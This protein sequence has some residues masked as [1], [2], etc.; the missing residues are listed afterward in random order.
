MLFS[1]HLLLNA[2]HGLTGVAFL[3]FIIIA[4]LFT[5]SQSGRTAN[6]GGPFAAAVGLVTF[7]HGQLT[8]V[9]AL[10]LA[11]ATFALTLITILS[12]HAA[13]VKTRTGSLIGVVGTWI[14]GWT[15]LNY[16]F[17]STFSMVEV[18][19]DGRA[20]LQSAP[21]FIFFSFRDLFCNPLQ[22][23]L[24][25]SIPLV[26]SFS[27]ALD[28]ECNAVKA[29][30]AMSVIMLCIMALYFLYSVADYF[31]IAKEDTSSKESNLQFERYIVFFA[32][33]IACLG[34]VLRQIGLSAVV[35]TLSY[36]DST[37]TFSQLQLTARGHQVWQ[38]IGLVLA[39]SSALHFTEPIA[40]PN[41]KE[42]K[43]RQK[44]LAM[45]CILASMFT[46][47]AGFGATIWDSRVLDDQN[48][49]AAA[50]IS[51]P[52]AGGQKCDLFRVIVAGEWMS[53]LAAF[54]VFVVAIIGRLRTRGAD[55]SIPG[56][57]EKASAFPAAVDKIIMTLMLVCGLLVALI[58]FV[59]TIIVSATNATVAV[60]AT[61][62]R[63]VA[64]LVLASL[65]GTP[66]ALAGALGFYR[67][68]YQAWIVFFV[69]MGLFL[70][71]FA[72]PRS[73]AITAAAFFTSLVANNAWIGMVWPNMYDMATS[74]SY[75]TDAGSTVVTTH[76]KVCTCTSSFCIDDN[77]MLCYLASS[78]G[79]WGA[80]FGFFGA[81]FTI[82][83]GI[84]F[85]VVALKGLR[86][87]N[88]H[89]YQSLIIFFGVFS[90]L[91]MCIMSVPLFKIVP[92][93]QRLMTNVNEGAD[94]NAYIHAFGA[95]S[96][97][98]ALAFAF[99][100]QGKGNHANKFLFLAE[101]MN[102][103]CVVIYYTIFPP[104]A[105]WSTHHG[106][107]IYIGTRG[108]LVSAP[109]E[110]G[111]EVLCKSYTSMLIGMGMIL[112]CAT[113]NAV[114]LS[115]SRFTTLASIDDEP[116]STTTAESN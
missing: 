39:L 13:R 93:P 92:D 114:L 83:L 52:C 112:V 82:Y 24:S 63:N 46:F 96:T 53:I 28:Y 104:F 30:G 35:Q 37:F 56:D 34:H 1:R 58:W 4:N 9:T 105:F 64:S 57:E 94:F 17:P 5:T 115:L 70:G 7:S 18:R 15:A 50:G 97:S 16:M 54:F 99:Q 25:T 45:L 72:A 10:M 88:F 43:L 76:G 71:W 86:T 74:Q 12:A 81:I 84:Q 55:E 42:N 59:N 80:L 8:F 22:A 90:A 91:G 108:N 95:I 66:G 100:G 110:D 61:S 103:G 20:M 26:G 89:I 98:S 51:A 87:I 78:V 102:W 33:F 75:V 36:A 21:R 2:L 106:S 73:P 48:L 11:V 111:N 85:F 41:S 69:H 3:A 29:G 101:S 38:T 14:V 79:M 77:N 6:I 27:P 49:N 60:T 40:D 47:F 116:T 65:P 31:A 62:N 107:G 68:T 67:Y 109:C 113:F 23:G 19:T 44:G 32:C